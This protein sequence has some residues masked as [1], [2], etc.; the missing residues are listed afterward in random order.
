MTGPVD[1]SSLI[2]LAREAACRVDPENGDVYKEMPISD[3]RAGVAF[4]SYAL[5]KST[6]RRQHVAAPPK[7]TVVAGVASLLAIITIL[8]DDSPPRP[9]PTL[10]AL[11]SLGKES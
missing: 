6:I 3:W 5:T 11:L 10:E 4:A 9:E 2:A 7:T 8:D 1:A